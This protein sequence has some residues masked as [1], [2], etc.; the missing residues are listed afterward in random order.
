M[1]LHVSAIDVVDCMLDVFV[2][3]MESIGTIHQ[4]I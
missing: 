4:S 3:L 1:Y 2:D